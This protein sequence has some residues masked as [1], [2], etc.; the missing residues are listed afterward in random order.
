MLH[1]V[2]TLSL[3]LA[4]DISVV[5]KHKGATQ[6]ATGLPSFASMCEPLSPETLGRGGHMK[7]F[8]VNNLQFFFTAVMFLDGV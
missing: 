1:E 6:S 2:E 3:S 8:L 5:S 4:I 7:F